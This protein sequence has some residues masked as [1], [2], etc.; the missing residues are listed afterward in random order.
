M[1]ELV[2]LDQAKLHLRYDDDY[3]DPDLTLKIRAGSAAI[4]S[5]VQG[6]RDQILDSGGNPVEGEA[7]ARAQAALLLLLG[8]LDRNR[9]GEEL[10]KLKQG[11]LP[12]SVTML[13]HDLRRPTIL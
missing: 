13:I 5:Y 3:N 8:Y 2:T 4:L 6:S 10:E 7:L 11:D 12:F 1:I 9:G